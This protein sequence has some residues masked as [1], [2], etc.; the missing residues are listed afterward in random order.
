MSGMKLQRIASPRTAD[1]VPRGVVLPPYIDAMLIV[2]AGV[3]AAH[4]A[5]FIAAQLKAWQD[6]ITTS[7]Q[8]IFREWPRA[9]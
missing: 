9:S 6:A 5:A 8:T 3:I 1:T 2:L 4:R 7:V